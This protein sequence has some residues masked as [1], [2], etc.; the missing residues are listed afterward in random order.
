ML[1][2]VRSMS[3]ERARY[4]PEYKA[5]AVRLALASGKAIGEVSG[6]IGVSTSALRLWIKQR[7][8]DEGR[9]P[10][11]ALKSEEREELVRLRR[12]LR[13]VKLERDFLKKASA[14]FARENS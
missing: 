14:F 12:E 9:G 6:D 5:E 3:R 1:L 7:E 10:A 2:E 11:G 13:Q 8:T 4:T